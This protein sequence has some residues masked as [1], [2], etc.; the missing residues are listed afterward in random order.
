MTSS[1]SFSDQSPI[2]ILNGAE[3]MIQIVL[4]RGRRDEHGTPTGV[5][6]L[7]FQEWAAP[8]RAMELLVPLLQEAFSKLSI[9]PGELRGIACV[10]GPGRFT[11]LRITL[12][13]ALGLSRALHLPLGGMEY[14]PL[15]AAGAAPLCQ[16]EIWAL[17]HARRGQVYIQGFSAPDLTPLHDAEAMDVE[18]AAAAIQPR[19]DPVYLLGSAVER[20]PELFFDRPGE[21][22]LLPSRFN[23]PAPEIL[24]TC[25][26]GLS[27]GESP[28]EPLYIRPSEAEENLS[29]ISVAKGRDPEAAG[30]R[31]AELLSR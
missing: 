11:G 13:I 4:G 30:R 31:L 25:A 27:F 17:T 18:D 2:L 19:R 14:L 16:G 23:R 6:T 21:C 28:V 1:A 7:M 8:G 12:S 3:E 15:L 29:S 24:L 5:E 10:R 26:V 9:S 22:V 20:Y